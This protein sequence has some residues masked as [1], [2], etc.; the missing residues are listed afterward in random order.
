M[1]QAEE[2]ERL[3]KVIVQLEETLASL[4]NYSDRL[5][6][7]IDSLSSGKNARQQQTGPLMCVNHPDRRAEVAQITPPNAPEIGFCMECHEAS[8]QNGF[9]C[10]RHPDRSAVIVDITLDMPYSSARGLCSDCWYEK[11]I[12][13]RL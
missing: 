13:E 10:Y 4:T 1:N 7:L 6:S 9:R 3:K 11:R 2:I 5:R 12:S 8:K